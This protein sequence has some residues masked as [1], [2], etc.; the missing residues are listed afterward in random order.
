MHAC[1][2]APRIFEFVVPD[3]QVTDTELEQKLIL[4]LFFSLRYFIVTTITLC[5]LTV[6]GI[7]FRASFLVTVYAFFLPSSPNVEI[8]LDCAEQKVLSFLSMFLTTST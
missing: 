8:M 2:H 7:Q 4:L 6:A 3:I 5:I 1:M